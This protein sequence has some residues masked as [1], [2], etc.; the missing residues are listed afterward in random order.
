VLLYGC[1]TWYVTRN[2]E[3][4]LQSFINNVWDQYWEYSGL[5]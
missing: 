4:K 2:I 3:R 5:K 1:E